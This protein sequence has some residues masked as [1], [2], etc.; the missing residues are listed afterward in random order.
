ME[1]SGRAVFLSV[2]DLRL[3]E[4]TARRKRVVVGGKWRSG[5]FGRRKKEL[6]RRNI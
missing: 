5:K 6:E 1:I 2:Y 4:I 3:K